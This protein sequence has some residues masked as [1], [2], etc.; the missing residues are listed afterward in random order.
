MASQTALWGA[1]V[2]SGFYHSVNPGM[3]WPLAV[4]AALMERKH[5]AMAKAIAMLRLGHFIAMIGIL[6]SFSLMAV[7]LDWEMQI[8]LGNNVLAAFTAATVHTL[9]MTFAGSIISIIIYFW[10]GLKFLSKT[11]FKL[12]VVWAISLILVG[13][14]GVY[15][16]HAGHH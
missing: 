15:S 3:G 12:D 8:R 4:S 16:A 5:S 14:F 1:V 13:L 9:A 2:F 6:L 11:W 10:L 7:L